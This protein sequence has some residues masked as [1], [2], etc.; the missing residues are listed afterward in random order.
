MRNLFF[1]LAFLAACA[2]GLTTGNGPSPSA[3]GNGGTTTANGNGGTNGNGGPSSA[4]GNKGLFTPGPVSS[5]NPLGTGLYASS[6]TTAQAS[7]LGAFGTSAEGGPSTWEALH[8]LGSTGQQADY[9]YIGSEYASHSGSEPASNAPYYYFD[10]EMA[11][12]ELAFR[13]SGNPANLSGGPVSSSSC[14]WS[15]NVDARGDAGGYNL[16][17]AATNALIAHTASGT[18]TFTQ[19]SLTAGTPVYAYLT[20][21]TVSQTTTSSINAGSSSLVTVDSTAGIQVNHWVQV[22]NNGGVNCGNEKVTQWNSATTFTIGNPILSHICSTACTVKREQAY[23]GFDPLYGITNTPTTTDDGSGYTVALSGTNILA[24]TT[25]E[26]GAWL[27][28]SANAQGVTAPVCTPNA[29]P[30]TALANYNAT[31]SVNPRPPYSPNSPGALAYPTAGT[32]DTISGSVDVY[33]VSGAVT[34]QVQYNP[35]CCGSHSWTTTTCTAGTA[36]NYT[37]T[38]SVSTVQRPIAPAVRFCNNSVCTPVMLAGSENNRTGWNTANNVEDARWLAMGQPEAQYTLEQ[39]C[40]QQFRG[41]Q[42]AFI[43]VPATLS[44]NDGCRWDDLSPVDSLHSP[45]LSPIDDSVDG[46]SSHLYWPDT[47]STQGGGSIAYGRAG[48][49]IAQTA[50]IAYSLFS[51]AHSMASMTHNCGSPPNAQN[52]ASLVY[53]HNTGGMKFNLCDNWFTSS[54]G[55]LNYSTMQ[56]GY[57]NQLQNVASLVWVGEST[58]V[59]P[60]SPTD[61]QRYA[62]VSLALILSDAGN[63]VQYRYMG[64]DTY[65]NNGVPLGPPTDALQQYV[66]PCTADVYSASCD[67]SQSRGYWNATCQIYIRHFTFGVVAFAPG[68]GGTNQTAAT[69]CALG[70]TYYPLNQDTTTVIGGGTRSYGAGVTSIPALSAN[71]G[72]IAVDATHQL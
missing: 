32:T 25:H 47:S 6:V 33:G 54:A 36:P 50:P 38:G 24:N 1:V 56:A 46:N 13:H 55:T 30:T 53:N 20:T 5:A 65:P 18:T 71:T 39:Q 49:E 45:D 60:I 26:Y 3:V 19:G 40:V 43:T 59:H 28:N 31:N 16:Y 64:A 8:P 70:G 61:A 12:D 23:D 17:N 2:P 4:I 57:Y 11:Y 67:F 63:H 42:A 37:C 51:N 41:P 22:C 34:M 62:A 52:P 21:V 44:P 66:G 9:S 69:S 72:W 15:W 14:K 48:L 29:L 7:V 10:K 58:L 35:G 27:S 68:T